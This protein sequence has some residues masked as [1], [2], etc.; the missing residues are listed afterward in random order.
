MQDICSISITFNL[1]IILQVFDIIIT[2]NTSVIHHGQI[3]TE[4]Y[5][6]FRYY[7]IDTKNFYKWVIMTFSLIVS[8]YSRINKICNNQNQVIIE[9]TIDK[10]IFIIYFLNFSQLTKLFD[11]IEERFERFKNY[12]ELFK[13]FITVLFLTHLNACLLLYFSKYSHN[14]GF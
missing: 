6:I 14:L 1:S 7:F 2:L 12:C 9:G 11:I 4:R 8:Q 5:Y 10:I 13:L 3:I